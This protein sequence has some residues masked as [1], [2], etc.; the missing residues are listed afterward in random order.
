MSK[1][2][3]NLD[4]VTKEEIVEHLQKFH[5]VDFNDRRALNEEEFI[6]GHFPNLVRDFQ[7]INGNAFNKK[8]KSNVEKAHLL[9]RESLKKCEK[10]G[11]SVI[12]VFDLNEEGFGE[13]RIC[14]PI[15]EQIEYLKFKRWLAM[16][17]GFANKTLLQG[18]L[19]EELALDEVL[20][21][22]KETI[23]EGQRK[24]IK[25]KQKS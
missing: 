21:D 9:I 25:V 2:T 11:I 3:W 1:E 13:Y 19:I 17:E 20:K 14:K 4:E 16:I 8:N 6:E 23:I 18:N 5:Q 10:E 22:I 12:R 24:R 15:Q 7:A